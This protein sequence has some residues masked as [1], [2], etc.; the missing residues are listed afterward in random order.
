MTAAPPPC[1]TAVIRAMKRA[2]CPAAAERWVL[3]ATVLGS[4]IAFID[5]TVVSVALP[6]LQTTLRASVSSAQWIVE[7]YSLFLSSLLLFGGSLGD[8]IGRRRTF[9]LGTVVFALSSLACGLAPNVQTIIA[10]RAVQGIGAALLV[11]SSL[12]ILGAAF[13]PERRGRAVGTWSALTSIAAAVGPALGGWLVQAVSWRAVFFL[14]LPIA[15]AVLTIARRHVPESRSP[16]SN[17]IDLAGVAL[18]T[19]GLGALVFGLIEVSS[20]GRLRWSDSL[21]WAPVAAGAVL[22]AAFIVV[23][24]REK[25]PMI[26]PALFRNRTFV[27]INLLT[28]FLYAALSAVFFFLP[29]DLIQARGYSPAAAGAAMLPFILVMSAMSRPSGALA[30]RLGP[31]LPLTVGPLL[32]AA[33]FLL[34]G[35]GRSPSFATSILPALVVF[36]LGMAITVTPLTTAVLNAVDRNAEGAASGINNAV[37]RVAGLLAVAVFG[38]VVVAAFNRSLDERL[39]AGGVSPETARALAPER[40]KLG[41]M[42][43]PAGLPARET[44]AI[45]DAVRGSLADAFETVTRLC[46]GL[47]L[48]A[49][50]SAAAGVAR[51]VGGTKLARAGGPER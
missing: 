16:D 1:D 23:E 3:A 46:A 15:A 31:R 29:F 13:S 50:A 22:L 20:G 9:S 28:F 51:T 43:P 10:A 8:R 14:N 27:A 18:A 19:F 21:V 48:L 34:L 44:R 47:T 41:A 4:T 39:A 33:G 40:P 36:G 49:S 25:N 42:K 30:D 5:G 35:A 45:A 11:P 32:A 26:P 6:V 7:A 12:A 24:L 38:I 17:R 2:P 37:A